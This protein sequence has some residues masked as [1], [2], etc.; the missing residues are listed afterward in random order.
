MSIS[1]TI[2]R[3]KL[4]NVRKKNDKVGKFNVRF[5]EELREQLKKIETA[6]GGVSINKYEFFDILK[7]KIYEEN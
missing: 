6:K 3:K 7:G 2:P 4:N 5:I 1:K